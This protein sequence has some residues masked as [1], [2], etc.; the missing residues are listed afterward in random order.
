M[1]FKGHTKGEKQRLFKRAIWNCTLVTL[2]FFP[3]AAPQDA[4]QVSRSSPLSS[5]QLRGLAQ[6]ATTML[7]LE[8]RVE[9]LATELG[10]LNCAGE[11][12]GVKGTV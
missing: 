12:C 2:M 7:Q 3:T 4:S 9:D 11:T 6:L 5:E 10:F 1:R 8:R